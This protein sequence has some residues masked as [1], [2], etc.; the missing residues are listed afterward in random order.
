MAPPKQKKPPN[1]AG[2]N[3]SLNGSRLATAAYNKKTNSYEVNGSMDPLDK[4]TYNAGRTAQQGLIPK[5]AQAMAISPEEHKA[6]VDSLYIPAATRINRNSDQAMDGAVNRFA[7]QGGL[8]S[9]SAG[10]YISENIER[11][12][13]DQLADASHQANLEAYNLPTLKLQQLG[14]AQD[15]YGSAVDDTYQRY[16]SG[17]NAASSGQQVGTNQALQQFQLQPKPRTFWSK[18]SNPFNL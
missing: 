7:S 2:G 10:N 18:V 14:A 5:V 12:R 11:Q 8:A 1:P 15:L 13:G 3:F 16:M 4:A 6:Y 17:I 9:R